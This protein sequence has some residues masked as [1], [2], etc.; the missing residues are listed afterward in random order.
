MPVP[1]RMSEGW[2]AG[3]VRRA[4]LYCATAFSDS[5]RSQASSPSRCRQSAFSAGAVARSAAFCAV[6]SASSRRPWFRYICAVRESAGTPERSAVNFSA[7]FPA[8]V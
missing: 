5:P 1:G 8:A 2:W 6:A 4:A 7:A 3:S